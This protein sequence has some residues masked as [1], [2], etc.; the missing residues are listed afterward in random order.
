MY[1]N[2]FGGMV[3]VFL[4]SLLLYGNMEKKRNPL[5]L[6]L[7]M[8]TM[9]LAGIFLWIFV[10]FWKFN[11]PNLM[12]K[13]IIMTPQIYICPVIMMVG[14][15]ISSCPVIC[16][17]A[18]AKGGFNQLIDR[19][20]NIKGSKG[21]LTTII[22]GLLSALFVGLIFGAFFIFIGLHF[23]SGFIIGLSCGLIFSWIISTI[24]GI[25]AEFRKIPSA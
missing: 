22:E 11:I 25:F 6:I 9:M 4:F 12:S 17:C 8:A 10:I 20:P 23:V 3:I 14:Y 21:I 5:W 7:G 24:S 19:N 1:K 16:F 2:I 13:N 18:A 15:F